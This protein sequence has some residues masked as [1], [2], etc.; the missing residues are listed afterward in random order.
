M[1][2]ASLANFVVQDNVLVGNTTFI[3]AQGPNCTKKNP[4]V[5]A[6]QAFVSQDSTITGSKLQ[7]GF[8][9]VTDGDNLN[10]IVPP[11]GGD[12]WPYGKSHAQ[13]APPFVPDAFGGGSGLSTGAKVGVA[14]AVLAGAVF[15]GLVVW[16]VPR[17][18]KQ[19]RN[20]YPRGGRG[21][22][23]QEMSKVSF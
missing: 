13:D 4:D 3:G 8:T 19:R 17:W 5:P 18:V 22:R 7:D 1:A 14:I 11:N 23:L 21:L 9:N 20:S 2:A 16:Y 6:S 15:V 12:Y 10:C